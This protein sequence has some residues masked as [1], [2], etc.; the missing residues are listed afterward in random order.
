MVKGENGDGD[1]DT[2]AV[3]VNIT[4]LTTS[5]GQV[6]RL[7][8]LIP[9]MG[10]RASSASAESSTKRVERQKKVDM[11]NAMSTD[12]SMAVPPPPDLVA[13]VREQ[14]SGGGKLEA[15][16]DP[17]IVAKIKS[18]KWRATAV[19]DAAVDEPAEFLG[20]CRPDAR[21][22]PL[23]GCHEQHK[24]ECLVFKGGGAKGAI[25][26]G[27]IRALEEAGVMPHI[28]RF[29]G[30]SAGSLVAALLAVGLNSEQLFVELA[31]TDLKPLVLDS[32]SSLAQTTDLISKWGAHPGHGLFRHLGILFYKYTGNADITF[33]ELYELYGVEL[34]V[35]V[36]NISRASVELLHVKTAPDYPIR[37]AVRASMS[38]PVALLPCKDKNIHGVI[39]D[40]VSKLTRAEKEAARR[41]SAA[42]SRRRRSSLG[43]LRRRS[44]AKQAEPGEV[45]SS[46]AAPMEYYVDGGVL[47]NYPIDSFDGARAASSR[48]SPA[49][50]PS[51]PT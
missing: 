16:M 1:N 30:A 18:G 4:E 5:S 14:K 40:D 42:G 15:L 31:T 7:L 8:N 13:A 29:A 27:A 25:Y 32:S 34:A 51:F 3:H 22:R 43:G 11:A 44:S 28:K 41:A 24:Y 49:P 47:N 17:A 21:K 33:R 39:S 6:E 26:P 12:S 48:V 23:P 19:D 46:A 38:L 2:E 10:R 45:G 20:R 9:G 50:P 37:K 36:T 35:A